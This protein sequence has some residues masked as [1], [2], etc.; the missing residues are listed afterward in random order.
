MQQRR[1]P[2]AALVEKQWRHEIRQLAQRPG[3]LLDLGGGS[4]YQGYITQEDVGPHTRYL[5]LDIST[6]ASPHLVAD[7]LDLPLRSASVDAVLCN[8]VLEHVRDP[9][10]AVSELYRV[11]KRP[12]N[13]LVSVPFIY[14]YHDVVDY[15]RFTDT[16]VAQMFAQFDDVTIVPVGD[17]LFSLL[18]FVTGFQFAL[19]QRLDRL[20]D[21]LRYG[22]QAAAQ[23]EHLAGRRRRGRNYLRS[24]ARSPVGWYIYCKKQ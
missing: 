4:P 22:M 8:A 18:L 16:A 21:P 15:Y 20:L 24:F 11:L 9:C 5:C 13:T 19:A 2:R 23:L 6:E 12:G 3:V 1:V 7:A 14:P 17:Y 10:Q